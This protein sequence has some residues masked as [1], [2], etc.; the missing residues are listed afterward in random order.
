[1]GAVYVADHLRIGRKVAIKR[2]HPELANDEKAVQRF[3]R[4][5]RAAGATGHEHI[6]EIL[7]LGYTEDGAPYLVMEYLRGFSLAQT[8]K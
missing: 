3:Q 1:M 5:A 4:E 8:L 6:V 7:D 2:L